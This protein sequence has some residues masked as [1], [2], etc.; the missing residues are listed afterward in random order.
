MQLYFIRHGQSTNNHLSATSRDWTLREPDPH[1]TDAGRAQAQQLAAHLAQ[2]DRESDPSADFQNTNGFGLTHLYCS[3]MTRA[4]QT[5]TPTAQALGLPLVAHPLIHEVHGIYNAFKEG[6]KWRREPLD[7]PNRSYFETNFPQVH[8][9]DEIGDEGWWQNRTENYQFASDRAVQFLKW[10]EATH[11]ADDRVGII[12]HGG[13]YQAF[14]YALLGVTDLPEN[15]YLSTVFS[16][17]NCAITRVYFEGNFTAIVYINKT[18][19]LPPEL[20]T[21]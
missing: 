10:V 1:L 19:H 21:R 7:G 18:E 8:L 11:S 6:E 9:P 16:I 5:A 13:F 17:N 14:M 12:S 15:G 4:I 20:H 3:L 2:P